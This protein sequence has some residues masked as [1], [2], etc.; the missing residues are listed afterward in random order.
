MTRAGAAAQPRGRTNGGVG[1]GCQLT[2]CTQLTAM[3]G[4]VVGVPCPSSSPVTR[5]SEPAAHRPT[6]LASRRG[7]PPRGRHALPAGGDGPFSPSRVP[8]V[9]R[10]RTRGRPVRRRRPLLPF[11][12]PAR[13]PRAHS[14]LTGPAANGR[15]SSSVRRFRRPRDRSR[16]PLLDRSPETRPAR[17]RP[18]KAQGAPAFQPLEPLEPGSAMRRNSCPS[19]TTGRGER[20]PN[21][22]SLAQ[23]DASFHFFRPAPAQQRPA[24][25]SP[26][27]ASPGKSGRSWNSACAEAPAPHRNP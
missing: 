7:V 14:R 15:F 25:K 19:R 17:T 12:R 4:D 1:R 10:A 26:A 21:A 24:R 27:S 13:F 18:Q 22:L 9:S 6:H 2:E 23:L 20:I 11:S 8:L 16:Q 5:R 3:V